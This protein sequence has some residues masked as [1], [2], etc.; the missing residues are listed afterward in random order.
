MNSIENGMHAT[1]SL[2]TETHNSFP[3]HYGLWGEKCLKHILT[4]L[5]CTTYNEVS[6]GHSH[7]LKHVYCK[8][9]HK[10]YKYYVYKFT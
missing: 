4:Y 5:D 2:F 8:E 6:I 3:I 7:T 9:C 10:K 1:I